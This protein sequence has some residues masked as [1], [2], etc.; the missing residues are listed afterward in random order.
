MPVSL[1]K[2]EF[3]NRFAERN[4]LFQVAVSQDVERMKAL[5]KVRYESPNNIRIELNDAVGD[6]LKR[7]IF[8]VV[9]LV[10]L[11]QDA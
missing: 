2:E 1:T 4:R 8:R 9:D 7:T 6:I 5:I 11:D 10:Y 3:L